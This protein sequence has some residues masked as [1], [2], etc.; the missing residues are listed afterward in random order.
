MLW[1]DHGEELLDPIFVDD[2]EEENELQDEPLD[3]LDLL[4][5]IFASI[6]PFG[7]PYVNE[8]CSNTNVRPSNT[9]RFYNLIEEVNISLYHGCTKMNKLEF[10]VCM[11]QIKRISGRFDK[12]LSLNLKL[13]KSILP[14]GETLLV[15]F[16]YTKKLIQDL[17]L[18]YQ[19]IY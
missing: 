14:D 8:D 9:E 2:M 5:D 18:T 6:S 15:N 3:M 16:Y 1:V 10:L 11:Y 12:S 17:D 13:I 4:T 7:S 19:K